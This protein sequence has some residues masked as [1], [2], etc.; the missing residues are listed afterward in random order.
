MKFQL[1]QDV[2]MN[3]LMNFFRNFV[4]LMVFLFSLNSLAEDEIDLKEPAKESEKE[5][6]KDAVKDSMSRLLAEKKFSSLERELQEALEFYKKGQIN[7][8]ELQKKFNPF[9]QGHLGLESLYNQWVNDFPDSYAARL[10]RGMFF[11]AMGWEQRGNR[12]ARDT[13]ANQMVGFQKF[14]KLAEADLI[15]SLKLNDKPL[16]SYHE[17]IRISGETNKRDM[18]RWLDAAFRAD[19][20]A[21]APGYSYLYLI[22]PKWGG[23]YKMMDELVDEI[24]ASAWSDI[25]KRQFEA[26]SLVYKGE[27]SKLEEKYAEAI[28]YYKKSYAMYPSKSSLHAAITSAISGNI[29]EGALELLNEAIVAD[30]KDIWA[31]NKRGNL[32]Q[33]DFKDNKKALYDF[34]AAAEVGDAW[35]QNKVGWWYF[36]G[37]EVIKDEEKAELYF[38]RAADQ[39]NKN[40][41]ANLKNLLAAKKGNASITT[42]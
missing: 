13:T 1:N 39:G 29:K 30:A 37:T 34:L 14:I 9:S 16:L 38:R 2:Y 33:A 22:T 15:F 25:E 28:Y 5:Q 24:K 20:Q 6:G 17:L 35:A 23:S 21:T 11:H 4:L 7:S 32:Y 26:R 10:S 27:H 40:A 31:L 8:E 3:D 36:T 18:R 42:K 19:P 12:F 41:K